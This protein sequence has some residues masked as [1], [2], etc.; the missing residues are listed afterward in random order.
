MR[1]ELTALLGVTLAV[2]VTIGGAVFGIS[3]WIED[4]FGPQYVAAFW[5]GVLFLVAYMLG[6]WRAGAIQ[7]Q[8]LDAIVDFQA[9]DDRGEVARMGVFREIARSGREFDKDVRRAALPLARHHAAAL[10]E[11]HL[12]E[13]ER[14]APEVDNW[15]V[16]P[17][18]EDQ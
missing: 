6:Q 3:Q 18:V 15:Y 9:A 4:R 11:R 2:L 10:T 17:E 5:L 1:Q 14:K 8:T 7:K 16:L 13:A 12:L